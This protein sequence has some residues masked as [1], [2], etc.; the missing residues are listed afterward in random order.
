MTGENLLRLLETRLDN[1]VFR[2]GFAAS[3]ARRASSSPTA[4]SRSTAAARPCRRTRSA[5]ATGSRCA[6]RAAS[7][8]TSRTQGG[9]AGRPATG[10]ADRRRRQAL[11]GSSLPCRAA[12]RCRS[13]STSSSW[14]S[15][16]RGKPDPMI[17]LENPQIEPVD[18]LE[19]YAKYEA[20]PLPA[21]YGVTIGNALRRVL[22]SSLE[23]A[24]VTSIQVRDV[25]HEFS[26]IPGVK[27]DVTQI[28]LNVKKLRLKSYAPHPVQLQLVK[29][30]AGAVTA[31]DIEET[32]DVEIVNP[33]QQLLTLDSDD[34][35]GRD[36]PDRR[37]RRRLPGRRASAS[38]CR[39]ASSRSTRS[40]RPCARSTTRRE[41]ARRP[42]DQ[43]RQA[44][45]RD[46]DRRHALARGGAVARRRD[47]RRPVQP[48]HHAP[49][50]RSPAGAPRSA[51]LRRCRRT[52]STCPS[53]SST[54]RCAPTTRSS[55]TTSSRSA[56]CCSSR[57]RTC[58]ACATS[59]RSRST[60]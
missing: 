35:T 46:R 15:S 50:R 57:T 37:A 60:R 17:E 34:V 13:S 49:A 33:D 19:T 55:A 1:V 44:D 2:M 47:P 16:T 24:A 45:H 21:G 8:S 54:S 39:S 51:A 53:R 28:V 31:H 30:G 58:C 29:S 23:G 56:S 18:E 7:R 40:S 3:R 25:Y 22:L 12:T 10:L 32:A 41:H 4:T 14:S 36:R 9:A 26:T 5:R 42:D 27:E 38:S 59:A 20:S 6:R 52:C 48:V 11:P 43:L